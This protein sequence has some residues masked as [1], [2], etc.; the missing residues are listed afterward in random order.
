MQHRSGNRSWVQKWI[1]EDRVDITKPE[2]MVWSLPGEQKEDRKTSEETAMNRPRKRKPMLC[3]GKA[4]GKTVTLGNLANR[5]NL[6]IGA[7]QF[8]R[9]N[10]HSEHRS[11]PGALGK[12]LKERDEPKKTASHLWLPAEPP[13]RQEQGLSRSTPH[14]ERICKHLL[15]EISELPGTTGCH[16]LL[17]FE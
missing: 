15:A 11:L 16:V 14:S 6:C 5:K 3:G 13:Q 12:V 1:S 10:A 8:P 2:N 4:M 9:Q 17:I 7:R